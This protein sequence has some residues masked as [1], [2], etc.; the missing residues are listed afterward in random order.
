MTWGVLR[1]SRQKQEVSPSLSCKFS[2]KGVA[3][4]ELEKRQ[5]DQESLVTW[6][7]PPH[8]SLPTDL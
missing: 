3:T 4:A 7:H 1:H 5:L 8:S 2:Y 6:P